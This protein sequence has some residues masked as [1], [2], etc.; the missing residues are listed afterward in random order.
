MPE[1]LFHFVAGE[2]HIRFE[3]PNVLDAWRKM[4][5]HAETQGV[6][7]EFKRLPI[8]ALDSGGA[9]IATRAWG[10]WHAALIDDID[11]GIRPCLEKLWG[12]GY[13]TESSCS[14]LSRDHAGRGIVRVTKHGF[15][16]TEYYEHPFIIFID[17][18]QRQTRSIL[19][20]ARWSLGKAFIES[21]FED[22][23][24]WVCWTFRSRWFYSWFLA[25]PG[26]CQDLAY[27]MCLKIFAWLLVRR[28][29]AD[30]PEAIDPY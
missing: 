14:G 28:P 16:Y 29:N 18:D 17:P 24:V 22:R 27:S 13:A 25:L 3:S 8:L 5:L 19:F 15:R 12:A 26:K 1:Q 4:E 20:A 21:W 23:R 6:A 2:Q 10:D 30:R 7:D 9:E 11:P